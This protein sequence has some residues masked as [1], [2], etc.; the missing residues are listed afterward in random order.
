MEDQVT[1]LEARVRMLEAAAREAAART[2]RLE[3][4]LW[5][6]G[7]PPLPA[8]RESSPAAPRARAAKVAA[9]QLRDLIL[10][11]RPPSCC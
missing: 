2:T 11:D 7:T 8:E 4:Q 10:H 9:A 6:V 1:E 5:P 3:R